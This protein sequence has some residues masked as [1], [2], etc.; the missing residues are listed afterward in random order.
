MD[1]RK[2]LGREERLAELVLRSTALSASEA[3]LF[4]EVFPDIFAVY[5]DQV[6][7]V[8]RRR[9]ARDAE[10]SDLV[11]DVFMAFYNQVLEQGFPVSIEAKLQGLAAERAMNQ[12]R[13]AKRAP[14]PLGLPSSRLEKPRSAREAKRALDLAML[15]QRLFPGLS[16]EHQ[17]VVRAIILRELSHDEAAAELGLSRTTVRSRLF[18]A[19]R[20]LAALAE[21]RFPRSQRDLS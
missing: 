2:T 19:K 5:Y 3:E 14:V 9:V 18:A 6:W 4:R 8:V 21:R 13:D 11:Q 15:T 20:R 10:L 16:Q 17:D 12:V 1:P 7:S